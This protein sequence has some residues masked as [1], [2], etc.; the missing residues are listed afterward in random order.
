MPK[1]CRE[2][3]R[4]VHTEANPL[5]RKAMM[6]SLA[7][8]FAILVSM[9][10]C[11]KT[12]TARWVDYSM[13]LTSVRRPAD[14]AERWGEYRVT[15][16]RDSF[17][18]EDDLIRAVIA[19]MEGAFAL[20]LE[21]KSEHSVQVVWDE[22][23]Y[24]GPDGFTSKVSS[25]DIRMIDVGRAQPPTVIPPG[26]RAAITAVPNEHI[27]ASTRDFL[28][29]VDRASELNGATVQLLVPL[30]VQDVTNEYTFL[31]EIRDVE[32]VNEVVRCKS[33]CTQADVEAARALHRARK[34]TYEA[35]LSVGAVACLNR[36]ALEAMIAAMQRQADA[37]L[38]RE[39]GRAGKALNV[40]VRPMGAGL[41][42]ISEGELSG[43]FWVREAELRRK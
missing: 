13:P 5:V 34:G 41:A 30:R 37:P 16:A 42:I 12:M 43:T 17:T 7:T 25:A 38:H 11:T 22:M 35:E 28:Q 24:V 27:G 4:D 26:A 39:C 9:A 14:A 10:G 8:L 29:S 3:G 36:E 33:V 15:E 18:Y 20:I 31:F 6:R 19:P 21:N 23:A 32:V 40:R 1:R 2:C